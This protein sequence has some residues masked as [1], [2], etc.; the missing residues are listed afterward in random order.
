VVWERGNFAS[1]RRAEQA[2]LRR[3]EAMRIMES[4]QSQNFN[5]R[6]SQWVANQGFWFQVRYSMSGS[7]TKGRAMF[8][9]LRLGFRL[10]IFVLILALGSWIYLWKRPNSVNF[11]QEFREDLKSAL[12]ASELELRGLQ[13]L[14]GQLEMGRLAAQGGSETFYDS[15][16]ARNIRCKMGLLD[17]LVGG[18]Q[19]GIISIA[20]LE[21]DL[22]AGTDDA[23]SAAMLADAV[24]RKSLAVEVN[25]FEVADATLRWGYSERTQGA[26]ESSTLKMQRT[27]TG[28]RLNFKGGMFH[29]NWLKRLE[30][31]DLVVLVESGG[32][33][34]ERAELRR[35]KGT[36]EFPGLR[37]VGGERPEVNG[38]VKI[39]NLVL[40]EILPPALRTFVEGSLSGDFKV[41]GSTNSSEGLAFEGQVVMD[42][43]DYISL[44]DRFHLLKALSVVDYSRSYHRVDF[45]E[46]SFQ[47]RSHRG[48][49]LLSDIDLKADDILTMQGEILVRLPTQQ[50]IDA[51]VA[52]GTGLETSAL[53]ANEDELAGVRNLPAG[54]SDFTLRR[55]AQEARRIQEGSQSMESLSLFDRLGLSI[56]MRRFQSQASERM[57]RMLRYEGGVRITLQAD[58]FERAP[59]L[60]EIYPADPV[61]GRI[62]MQVPI[63][64]HLYELTLR[65]A[66]DIYQQGKR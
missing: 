2:L 51:A 64:G 58:A 31:V 6:L 52:R 8:H 1:P 30:I 47:M 29:Q 12:S 20:R 65:Q 26:I 39:R 13:H 59:R 54:E 45:R 40:E 66:E 23:D 15:L 46:G 38:I 25:S 24:F 60:N 4:E 48:G 61:T 11:N 27:D 63:I 42:G 14:Q 62:Q 43:Q 33:V 55:A 10:L 37:V 41:S 22:R 21:I 32:I 3:R 19:P 56:E 57:S 50:E 44:R 16:E 5:E 18:W 49:L 9:L 34:F 53:F 36:V 28:W 35:L 7:G 17:G